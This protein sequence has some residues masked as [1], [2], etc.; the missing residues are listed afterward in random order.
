MSVGVEVQRVAQGFEHIEDLVEAHR[1][2]VAHLAGVFERQLLDVLGHVGCLEL[3]GTAAGF[4]RHQVVGD[5]LP[6]Q[7]QRDGVGGVT[8]SSPFMKS[9]AS[10]CTS[11]VAAQ[12]IRSSSTPCFSL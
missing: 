11:W 8:E 12:V 2:E 3:R 9:M 4:E 5:H 1:V 10:F 6:A 7:E